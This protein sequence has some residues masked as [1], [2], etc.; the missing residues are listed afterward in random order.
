MEKPDC[1]PAPMRV[2][3]LDLAEQHRALAARTRAQIDEVLRTA[4]FT[5]GPKVEEFERAIS[6]Y[7]RAIC[8]SLA[9]RAPKHCLP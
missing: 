2:P 6:V 4:Q 5:L 1:D 7:G 9:P 3:L 8:H